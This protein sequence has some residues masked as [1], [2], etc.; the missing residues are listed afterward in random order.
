MDRRRFI[1]AAAA[2]GTC[3]LAGWPV[4]AQIAR[5]HDAINQ[6]GRQRML[7]QRMAKSYLQVGQDIDSARSNRIFTDSIAL[8]ERQ[9]KNLQG[10][11]PSAENRGT[12]AELDAVWQRYRQTLTVA[13]PNAGDARQVMALSEEVLALAHASTLQLE[14][15]S[16]TETG[17]LVNIA[18][19]QRMLSQR[20]A[21]FY[22]AVN[23]G[24][25]PAGA[26][27]ALATARREFLA[28]LQELEAAPVNT[29][30]LL[31]ELELARQQW[32]FFDQALRTAATTADSRRRFATNVATT[33][34][35]ILETM[36]RITGMYEQ[37][38]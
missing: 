28:A 10:F 15:L 37:A 23:W 11:A 14:A 32:F 33:S 7:S 17:H 16:A 36:D 34:E 8:F 1:H 29:R 3:L 4:H 35:R 18:G 25:A 19:R 5:I 22:Q 20:M 13:S 31:A 12:L 9:L 26:L 30:A 38:A 6:S 2:A 27:D 24:V 21:K